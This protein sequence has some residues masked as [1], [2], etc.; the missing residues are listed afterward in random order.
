[1]NI[2]SH[3]NDAKVK[4]RLLEASRLIRSWSK[5]HSDLKMPKQWKLTSKRLSLKGGKFT[6][7][8]GKAWHCKVVLDFLVDYTANL[9]VDPLLKT[10]LWAAQN[11][12]VLLSE[13]RTRSVFLLPAEIEQEQAVGKVFLEGYLRLRVKYNGWCIYKLFNV[14]PKLHLLTHMITDMVRVRNPVAASGW[15]DEDF[16]K[17]VMRIARK[18]HLATTQ[19]STLKRYLTGPSCPP[20]LF[21]LL[22]L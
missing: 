20:K 15:M 8:I 5:Q 9:E 2:F 18:T 14:R 4:V 12:F 7:F 17:G 16:L 21:G 11:V 10:V 19:S 13:S 3:I 6:H 22:A 1:M